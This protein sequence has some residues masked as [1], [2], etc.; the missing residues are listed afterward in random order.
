[1][2]PAPPAPW[3][4]KE[5]HGKPIVAILACHSGQA[6][7]G[8]EGASPRS[9]RSA[10]PIGDVLVRRPYAQMQTLLDATQPK[11]R[12]YYWKSEYLPRIEPE[13]VREGH[14]AR[15]EDP[16]AALGGDPV[17]DRRRA[18]PARATITRRSATATRATCS[19]SRAPGSRPEDDEA[20]IEWAREAWND[21]QV[22]LD[23]RH[24]RQ[25]PDRGRRSRAHRGGARQGG[26]P[27]RRGQGEVGSAER[28]PHEPQHPAGLSG[29]GRTAPASDPLPSWRPPPSPTGG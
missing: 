9:S 5:M 21:L 10:S 24:L 15:G 13:L 12:R 14:R 11:G 16:L 18:E 6:R 20:N 28:V 27:A 22:V 25:L 4:P 1:M 19:T 17:P 23:R 8:R 26:S 7:G 3:L 29:G 2:R